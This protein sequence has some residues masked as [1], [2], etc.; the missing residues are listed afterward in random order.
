[1]GNT[2]AHDAG[3]DEA[4]RAYLRV[5]LR[6][7]EALEIML[8]QGMLESGVRRIGAEQEAAIIDESGAPAPIADDLLS[9]LPDSFTTELGRF[10]IEMNMDPIEFGGFA[11]RDLEHQIHAHLGQVRAVAKEHDSLI[12]LVGI[13][14]SLTKANLTIDNLSDR[15]RYH[16]MNAALTRLRGGPY[17]LNIA[18]VDDL[19]ISHDNIMLESCNTSFQVHF[20]VD[21]DQFANWY[22]LAQVASAPVLAASVNSPVLLGRKLWQE[23]RI[24]LFQ[25]S[26][27]TRSSE[28]ATRHFPPRVSFGSDWVREGVLEIFKEDISRFKPL[29]YELP[30]EDPLEALQE[31]RVPKLTALRLFNGTVYRWNRACYGILN[32]K[33]HL[34]IEN[35]ILPSGPTP[36]DEVANAAL[37]LGFVRGLNDAVE[38]IT[39]LMEF[40]DVQQDF[41][42]AARHG[43]DAQLHWLDGET[44]PA[45]ELL[46]TKVIPMAS[47][48]LL[49]SGIDP[50]DVD[51][52]MG[53][54]DARVRSG[55]TGAFW[56]LKSMSGAETEESRAQVLARI[57]AGIAERQLQNAPVHT[58]PPL[59][60]DEFKGDKRHVDT[61]GQFMT[62]D[63]FTVHE[64]DVVDLVTNLMDWK[65]LRRI[66]VEDDDHALVGLVT[67]R[68]LIRHLARLG[69]NGGEKDD[70]AAPVSTIMKREVITV[71]PETP[72]IE[73]FR[74]L[75]EHQ[76]GCLPV[77][78]NNK[79][80]GIITEYDFMKIADPMLQRFLEG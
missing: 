58:W 47:A 21:P 63:L 49:A 44:H 46:T 57:S 66:P 60:S 54:I 48:G 5:L 17:D 11:L 37:W 13:L 73:A 39:E 79:L 69:R 18:G 53:V 9:R 29:F 32:G 25:Q 27:D 50:D 68:D 28:S 75:R 52:Y 70:A 23:T 15:P 33:P 30:D 19:V 42:I 16:A 43:L 12:A 8:S 38:D 71:T 22:N 64:S 6:D 1:M 77:V 2:E 20:Q 7:V 61:V 74:M 72:S 34:R 10:N 51:R 45:R 55:N 36:I 59:D 41:L 26:I 56:I 31:G 67:H 80:V 14:P 35:R 62:T 24:A 78:E 4:R 65:H 76:I 3:T 40:D